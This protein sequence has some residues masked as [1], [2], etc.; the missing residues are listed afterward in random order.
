MSIPAPRYREAEWPAIRNAVGMVLRQHRPHTA[1][2]ASEVDVA[3]ALDRIACYQRS[4]RIAVSF[5]S[6]VL[7]CLAQAAVAIPAVLT[8]RR[9]NRLVTFEEADVGT[10]LEKRLPDGLRVPVG[11]I[12][13]AADRKSL[14]Q[15]NWELRR[16]AR[17]DLQDEAEVRFRRRVARLP[18]WVRRVLSA[19]V[20]RDPFLLRRIHGT[21]GLTNVQTR[22][23]HSPFWVF[24]PNIYTLT[25][26]IGNLTRRVV[27]QPDG[28]TEVRKVQCIS[29]GA[30][31]AVVDG[32]ALARFAQR[33]VHLVET[34]DGLDAAFEEQS[35]RFLQTQPA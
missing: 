25:M 18:G 20:V 11:Y 10:V 15:I 13:R 29:S 23:F 19:R 35:S 5:H 3:E 28:T 33:F 17:S 6:F 26:A 12:V 16:A 7:H 24:P 31:H 22:A 21:I 9:G 34:A 30:D 1:Y 2:G 32:M 27:A 8:Y 14:A 4:L